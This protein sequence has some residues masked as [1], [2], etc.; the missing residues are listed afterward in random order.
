VLCA[1]AATSQEVRAAAPPRWLLQN[2]AAGSKSAKPV[3]VG[4]PHAR[5]KHDFTSHGSPRGLAGADQRVLGDRADRLLSFVCR[6]PG[7]CA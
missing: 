1:G 5:Q 6:R 2:G 7:R 3:L 4:D